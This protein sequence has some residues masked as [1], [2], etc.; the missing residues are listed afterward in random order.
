M[1]HVINQEVT[2]NSFYFRGGAGLKTFP[3]SIEWDG[4][5]VTFAEA[6]LRYLVKQGSGLVQLFD[7]TEGDTTYRLRRDGSNWTLV[8]TKVGL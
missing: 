4:R 2:V 7:M 1:T 8:G 3:R 5:F 6:G